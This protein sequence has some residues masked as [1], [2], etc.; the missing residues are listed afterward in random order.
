MK[1]RII[2]LL[3]QISNDGLHDELR[4]VLEIRLKIAG[5]LGWRIGAGRFAAGY[6]I[7]DQKQPQ[8]YQMKFFD[9]M[10]KLMAKPSWYCQVGS[11]SGNL[12]LFAGNFRKRNIHEQ[13]GGDF[14]QVLFQRGQIAAFGQLQT[15]AGLEQGF[16]GHGRT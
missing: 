8:N 2:N 3:R 11:H 16:A 14:F 12:N 13:I 9:L 1:L 5:G 10:D 4:F 6:Q 7:R 15:R